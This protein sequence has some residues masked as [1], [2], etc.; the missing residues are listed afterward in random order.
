[1]LNVTAGA[2]GS[3]LS[4]VLA[5]QPVLA[6][7]FLSFCMAITT[8]ILESKHQATQKPDSSRRSQRQR[9]A[10]TGCVLSR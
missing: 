9:F 8:S 3:I 1:M 10:P 5:S 7:T 4:G 2:I 6:V